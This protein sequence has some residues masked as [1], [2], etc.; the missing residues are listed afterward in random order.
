M[1]TSQARA[2]VIAG[3]EIHTVPTIETGDLVIAAD[4]GYDHAMS[5]DAP[6]GLLIGDLDSIS[7]AGLGHARDHNVEIE[8]FPRGKDNTDLELALRAAL[9]RG[10]TTVD[11]HGGESGTIAHL[12]GVALSI[13]HR[14]WESLD[15]VWHT[16][17]GIVRPVMHD[18]PL[19]ASVT[20]GD[21]VTIIPVG[22]AGRITTSGLRW[23][24]NDD[25][26]E[27]GSTLGISN[28]ATARTITVAVEE[29]ALLV[30][31][32]GKAHR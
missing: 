28:E 12:L 29:G 23:A 25:S 1:T 3:G 27:R 18:R 10:A 17:T 13:A 26:M 31:Q 21:V 32:E 16:R 2:V 22:D 9:D 30:V 8:Q 7:P 20:L 4:S 11:I 19:E 6:V 5:L 15:I 14:D 24:L